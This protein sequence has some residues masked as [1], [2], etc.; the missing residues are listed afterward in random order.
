MS[1]A[2]P[3]PLARRVLVLAVA[4]ALALLGLPAAGLAATKQK[5]KVKVSAKSIKHVYVIVLENESASATFG[6][7]SPAPYLAKTLRS[8][9]AYLPNYYATGHQ[10]NDNYISMISGQAPNAENQA[11]CQ[12]YGDVLPGTIGPNGQAIGAGC[13]YPPGV[14]TIAS[15]LDAAGLSWRDY[16]QDMGADPQRESSECGHPALNSVDGTQKASAVDQYATRHNPFVYFHA[17]IDDT[18]LCDTHVVNFAQLPQ[19][20]SSIPS[21]ANYTFITPNLCNDGHDAPCAD[22]EPGGLTQI[23]T[24]LS[25]WVPRITRSPAFK[26]NGLLIITFDEAATSDTSSCCGEIPGP[27]SPLPGVTGPGGGNVGAV[28]LSPC[29]APGTV[30]TKYY[31]HYSMLGSV[32]DIF[33]LSHIGYAALPGQSYFGSDIYNHPCASAA[34]KPK[35]KPKSKRKRRTHPAPPPR[36]TG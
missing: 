30:S 11:D 18:T 27:G 1:G 16:N 12:F 8:E 34:A 23:N 36:F 9:G 13:V 21:T 6:P 20:L 2:D 14:P 22:G 7:N 4:L 33:G 17:I 31:N 35:A 28:L 3:R 5:P 25:Q 10:S 19:D 26:Q 15:Q 24:F 32:E 29:I